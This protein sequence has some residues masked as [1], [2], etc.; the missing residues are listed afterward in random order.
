[1]KIRKSTAVFL[2]GALAIGVLAAGCGQKEETEPTSESGRSEER[3]GSSFSSLRT[4]TAKT[5]DENVFT[6]EDISKKDVTVINF[7]SL[8]CGPCIEEMP[9]LAQFE[10]A[11]P[12]H[13]QAL[14]VCLDGDASKE[15]ARQIL[16]EAGFQGTTL[17][18]GDGDFQK[19]CSQI[20]YT[21]TTIFLDKDGN[22]AAETIIGGQEDLAAAYTDAINDALKSMGKEEI[23]V[24][25]E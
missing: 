4:F 2:S 7:W 24:E 3:L 11:L 12:D 9:D 16:E 19:I 14:T 8:F 17:L 21:P 22:I 23:T 20:Q 6:R 10:K 5:L 1:M 13:V 18:S 25:R 15:E